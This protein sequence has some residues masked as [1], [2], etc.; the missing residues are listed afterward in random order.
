MPNNN[1]HI[2]GWLRVILVFITYLFLGAIFYPLGLLIADSNMG[3]T[4][5]DRSLLQNIIIVFI[6][7]LATLSVIW[8]FVKFIDNES[9]KDIG[10]QLG[11]KI[12]EL[13]VG[14]LLGLFIMGFA[15]IFLSYYSQV[16]FENVNFNVEKL[17][18]T[19][20]L[21]VLI[22][23]KEEILTRGYILR[24]FMY[25]YNKLIALILSS[26][27]FSILHGLNPDYSLLS[28]INILLAGVLL[29]LP[30][31][32]NKNLWFPIALHFSWNFFQSL[33]GFNVS[34]LDTYSL[35]EI[36]I[37]ESNLIN[38][39]E[40]GFEGSVLSIIV[41]VILIACIYLYYNHK[42]KKKRVI[43]TVILHWYP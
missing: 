2:K 18:Y 10:F 9:F 42:K 43:R 12:M 21:F 35:I 15:L 28:F 8:V 4:I 30:Y 19:F 11:S 6:D 7:F 23:F 17:I 25:S 40:F 36:E 1:L 26:L 13:I 14:I 16:I 38:G 24:N 29:G 41:Q 32:Y 31:T 27:I 33:F 5:N 22:S 39:G 37:P 34:G 20:L 3:S